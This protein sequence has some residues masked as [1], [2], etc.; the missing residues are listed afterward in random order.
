MNRTIESLRRVALVV[1]AA[2]ALPAAAE[3]GSISGNV[4]VTPAKYLAETVV[5]VV[6][7]PGTFP[8]KTVSLDQKALTFV[9]HVLVITQGDSVTFLNHDSVAHNAYSPDGT[10]YNLGTFQPSE[11]RT[12]RL[13][14]WSMSSSWPRPARSPSR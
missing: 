13:A 4:T 8:P 14:R 1:C 3:P 11:S 9:P 7:A 6:K 2:A 10:P 5:Y 12:R